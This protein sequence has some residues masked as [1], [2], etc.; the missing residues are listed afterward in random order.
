[1]GL[2]QA[3]LA[4]GLN[5]RACF[6]YERLASVFME[7]LSN[8]EDTDRE[9][10]LPTHRAFL[11]HVADVIEGGG[12]LN[13]THYFWDILIEDLDF[14]FIKRDLLQRNPVRIPGLIRWRDIIQRQAYDVE[15]ISRHLRISAQN[16][17]P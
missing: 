1:M 11:A 8:M 2:T 15:L 3:L 16:H 14:P 9:R 13:P 6:P 4:G 5:C 12:P 10:L 17:V 7:R